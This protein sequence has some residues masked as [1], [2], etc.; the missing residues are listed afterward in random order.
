MMLMLIIIVNHSSSSVE[1]GCMITCRSTI[2]PHPRPCSISSMLAPLLFPLLPPLSSSL[3]LSSQLLMPSCL[4]YFL[5]RPEPFFAL[6]KELYPGNFKPT[7]VHYFIRLLHDKGLLLRNYTQ[8][9]GYLFLLPPLLSFLS[10]S[11]LVQHRTLT[12][13]RGLQA[14]QQSRSWKLMV[15]FIP[16]IVSNVKRSTQRKRLKVPLNR[17]LRSQPLP[18]R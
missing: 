10:S 4:R 1:R 18:R 7:P 3:L 5:H 9:M 2:Y 17:T 6:A 15:P 16:H 14:C 13:W 12:D 11:S 8:V